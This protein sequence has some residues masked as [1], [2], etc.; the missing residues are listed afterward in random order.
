MKKKT[1][2]I[3]VTNR[4]ALVKKAASGLRAYYLKKWP[5]A[6]MLPDTAWEG[7]ARPMLKAIGL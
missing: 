4:K 3:D 5:D 7:Y 6:K 2:T 1:K